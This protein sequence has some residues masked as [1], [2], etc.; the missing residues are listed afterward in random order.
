M[1]YML[2][3]DHWSAA[4]ALRMGTAQEV[5]PAPELAL[6]RA[7]EIAN[8][9]AACSPLGIKTTL[10]SGHLAVDPQEADALAKTEEQYRALYRTRDFQEGR[11]AEAEGRPPVYY[12]N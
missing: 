3:G 4:D 5:A 11:K 7:I 2:T 1:R 6:N 9:I 12:G 10:A 8:K